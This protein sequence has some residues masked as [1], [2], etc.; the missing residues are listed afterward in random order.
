MPRLWMR[1]AFSGL[2]TAALIMGS[3]ASVW[4]GPKQE[5]RANQRIKKMREPLYGSRKPVVPK[6]ERQAKL[7]V[8]RE[9]KKKAASL[10]V[11]NMG[12]AGRAGPRDIDRI[13]AR[14][15]TN[16]GTQPLPSAKIRPGIRQAARKML[17]GR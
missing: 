10:V 6:S 14:G 9:L 2:I 15:L 12:N 1:S 13:W 11:K 7:K 5:W 16:N 8:Y 4:A 17:R 3:T